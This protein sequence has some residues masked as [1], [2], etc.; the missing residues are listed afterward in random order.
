MIKWTEEDLRT[1][2]NGNDW[3]IV[4]EGIYQ[5]IDFRTGM[6]IGNSKQAQEVLELLLEQLNAPPLKVLTTEEKLQN[7]MDILSEAVDYL[8]FGKEF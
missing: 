4:G 7:Q 8:L 1:E 3:V 6:P 2:H 5:S